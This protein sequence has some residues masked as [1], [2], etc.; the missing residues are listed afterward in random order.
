MGSTHLCLQVP[1]AIVPE[2]SNYLLNPQHPDF[3]EVVQLIDARPI[4][5]DNRV[6]TNLL[7]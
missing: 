4:L 2:E 6:I 1:S 5:L 7:G 3:P